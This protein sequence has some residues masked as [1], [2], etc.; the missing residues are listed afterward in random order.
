MGNSLKTLLQVG[1]IGT[2]VGVFGG[3]NQD[4]KVDSTV[5]V[6]KSAISNL[7]SNK[8]HAATQINPVEV[9]EAKEVSTTLDLIN[10]ISEFNISEATFNKIQEIIKVGESNTRFISQ[11]ITDD[12]TGAVIE[13]YKTGEGK[14]G[15][16]LQ[17]VSIDDKGNS[18]PK[19]EPVKMEV[20][21][22]PLTISKGLVTMKTNSEGFITEISVG[23]AS[24]GG[25][26]TT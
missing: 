13:I 3:E 7:L 8:A 21:N 24:K 16:E 23:E 11:I 15:V 18:K 5:D 17:D 22:G 19:G 20:G 1:V 4:K 26:F 6:S 14:M 12:K 10:N 9:R 2:M 25:E